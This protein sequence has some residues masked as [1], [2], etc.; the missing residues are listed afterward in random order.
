MPLIIKKLLSDK[1]KLTINYKKI[2]LDYISNYVTDD[3][4]KINIF[5]METVWEY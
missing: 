2:G 4:T 5:D 1:H 3:M